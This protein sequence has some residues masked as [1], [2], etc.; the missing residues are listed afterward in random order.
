MSK[1]EE[2]NFYK[3]LQDFFI[4]AD[5]KTFLQFLAEFYNRTEGIID[6]DNIQDDLIKELREL[7]LE[8][9]E[10]GI[11]NNIVREKVNYF[12]ENNVKIKDINSKLIT[13]TN[14]IEDVNTK[15]NANTNNITSQ[16]DNIETKKATKEEVEVERKRIDNFT[17]LQEGSTTGD[18]ELID[19]RTDSNGITYSN[20]GSH[21]RKLEKSLYNENKLYFDLSFVIGKVTNNGTGVTGNSTN[22]FATNENFISTPLT[23]V[24]F[25]CNVLYRILGYDSNKKYI[26]TITDWITGTNVININQ[27][28]IKIN[29]RVDG[30]DLVLDDIN[31]FNAYIQNA[32][33]NIRDLNELRLGDFATISMR[34]G[35]FNI[36]T[37]NKEIVFDELPYVFY[38]NKFTQ[39]TT[40]NVD[41]SNGNWLF[42]D[43]KNNLLT[44][45]TTVN[46]P[47]YYIPIGTLWANSWYYLSSQVPYKVDGIDVVL[48]AKYKNSIINCLGDS[49]TEGVG[50]TKP[51]HQWLKQL[52]GFKTVN[53]YGIGSSTISRRNNDDVSWDTKTPFVDRW[54]NMDINAKVNLVWGGVNDFILGRTLGSINSTEDN[55]FYGALKII[56]EGMIEKYTTSQIVF[57]TPMQFNWKLRPPV[58]NNTD[59]TN[60]NGNTLL[61]F[62][63]AI[64]DVCGLYGIPV[65]DMYNNCFYGLSDKTVKIF[66][67]DKLHPNDKGHK[68]KIAPKIGCFINNI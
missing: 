20:I 44:C 51:Y 4:N 26:G 54:S 17:K 15:L 36:D 55:T 45:T 6:K 39:L 16:L 46:V 2:S 9:N 35:T 59:G 12:L 58:G 14:K 47:I 61:D 18:A 19:G 34:Y 22:S 57:V 37:V 65:L 23:T 67:P 1:F 31:S 40:L 25:N 42:Y 64:K 33:Y 38:R 7:Y 50:C 68:E 5:K 41:I 63:N 62:V 29:V 66:M 13:N 28:Y 48:S 60:K 11:D 21:I 43:S 24:V 32:Q 30:R 3:A 10:K 27:P 52:C 8:F 49:I 53:N 56:C